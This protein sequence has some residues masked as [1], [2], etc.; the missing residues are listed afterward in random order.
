ME[1]AMTKNSD[2]VGADDAGKRLC[3]AASDRDL[4]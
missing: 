1:D 2:P 4:R 3:G